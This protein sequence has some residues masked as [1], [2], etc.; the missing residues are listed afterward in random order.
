MLS[1]AGPAGPN[2]PFEGFWLGPFKRFCCWTGPFHEFIVK[3]KEYRRLGLAIS[4]IL[5]V[6]SSN[7]VIENRLL[8]LI[9]EFQ[10][11]EFEV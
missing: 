8:M 4:Y 9:T 11:K 3:Y 7:A 10:I 2:G 6:L 5:V 1:T